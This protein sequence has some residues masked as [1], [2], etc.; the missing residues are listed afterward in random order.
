MYDIGMI[1]CKE[2]GCECSAQNALGYHLRTHGLKYPDYVVKHEHGGIWP[3]CSCGMRLEHK[4]GG[5]SRFC[6]KSCASAGSNNPMAGK[7][8]EKSPNYGLKRTQEQLKNYSEGAKKRWKIHGNVL[9]D[10][11][12]T[13]E[14][15]KANSE[16]QK[17][18][19]VK[20]P[21][22]KRIRSESVHRF[23]SSSPLAPVLREEASQRAIKLLAEDKIGPRTPF[24]RETL[25]NPWTGENEVMHSSWE[26][27][28]FETCVARQ[29]E[30]TKNHGIVIPYKHPD[31]TAR[32][33]IPDFFGREDRVL[34]EM[35]GRHDEVDEA[36]WAAAKDYCDRM[37]WGFVL[38][39]SP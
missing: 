8:G 39:L 37:G 4:K 31:G 32:N 1:T 26:S 17:L 22:L 7:T 35:K 16:G 18:S 9:R 10:M 20:N 21:D 5:F 19:Y 6:S 3:T 12:K 34:Y 25:V 11:M 28:F 13:D 14:Y 30:V 23:W 15:R 27:A 24:K 2:C 29:Y 36:K 33:Y 38:M